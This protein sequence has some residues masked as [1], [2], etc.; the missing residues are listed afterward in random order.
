L[1]VVSVR[2]G[3]PELRKQLFKAVI[4]RQRK[5]YRR[6]NGVRVF[7]EDNAAVL[8]TPEGDLKGTE[9]RGPVAKEAAERWV[10]IANVATIIV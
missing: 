2:E 1:V 7:F 6:K 10:R 5:M 3:K 8:L 4:V 9:I